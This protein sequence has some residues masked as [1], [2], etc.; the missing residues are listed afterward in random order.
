MSMVCPQCNGAFEQR[1]QCPNCDVRLVYQDSHPG[2]SAEVVADLS[3]SWQQTPW[4]RL[5]VGLLLSQG[6][7]YVLRH[8]FTAGFLV[9]REETAGSIWATLTGLLVLQVLQAVGVVS[10]GLLAGAGQR[11]GLLF[12]AIVGTCNGALLIIAQYIMG[13]LSIGNATRAIDLC[14]EPTL[15]VAFGALGGLAGSLIWKPPL[16]LALPLEE[17]NPLPPIPA[18]PSILPFAGPVAWTRVVAGLA[19][20]VGGVIWADVIREAVLEA[21]EGKLKI[22]THLQAELITWEIS[23]LAMLAGSALAGATTRNGLKQGLC[24]GTG[25]AIVLVGIRLASTNWT[26]SLLFLTAA[27]TLSLGLAGGWFGSDLLPPVYIPPKRR[28]RRRAWLF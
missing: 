5:F 1:I 8:L 22:N 18:Q 26:F 2:W 12:G 16:P 4:G 17:W 25:L 24:V 14:G 15:Q 27:S 3:E 10:G 21:S 11:R 9:V 23:A 20:A 6:L 19:L 7:Y 28:K 13:T